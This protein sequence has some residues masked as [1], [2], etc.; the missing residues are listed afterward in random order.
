MDRQVTE[1]RFVGSLI[2][3]PG[4]I[5]DIEEIVAPKHINDEVAANIYKRLLRMSELSEP[6]DFVT[7]MNSEG[8]GFAA[9][10]VTRV[11]MAAGDKP[12][13]ENVVKYAE[14]IREES[15]RETLMDIAKE[16]SSSTDSV[17]DVVDATI[18]KLAHITDVS[19][20]NVGLDFGAIYKTIDH[21]I[22]HDSPLTGIA[23][24]Y[25]EFNDMGGGMQDG[26]FIVIAGE[27]SQFKTTV[28]TNIMRYASKYGIKSKMFSLE[29]TNKQ[30][31]A[32]ILAQE[33]KVDSRKI[34]Y[35]KLEGSE[36]DR[37]HEAIRELGD[38]IY[39][40]EMFSSDLGYITRGIKSAV[41]RYGVKFVVVD[42]MQLVTISG[43]QDPF[44]TVSTVADKLKLLARKLDIPIIGISQL[45]RDKARPRP[46]LSRLK[47]SGNIENSADIVWFSW[48]PYYYGDPTIDIY[49][50]PYDSYGNLHQIIAKGRNIGTGEFI[51]SVQP[52]Y[53][54]IEEYVDKQEFEAEDL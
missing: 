53:N 31:T 50:T 27:T 20:G 6:I 46:S 51:V 3:N 29:M 42:Y 38:N 26:D 32:R 21:N 39:V 13:K 41:M 24:P 34:L 37:V 54:L 7:V 22:T 10:D 25:K 45:S 14:I 28:A 44:L 9:V 40:D 2:V 4:Y 23:T 5:P 1:T 48:N 12:K 43:T 33:A 8:H 17:Y 49:G 18:D 52:E 35:K 47:G 19:T 30:L 15:I 11:A 16:I 36:I